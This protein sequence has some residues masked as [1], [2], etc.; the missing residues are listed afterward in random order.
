MTR[1][2][3]T[4]GL[5]ALLATAA[6][7]SLLAAGSHAAAPT[8]GTTVTSTGGAVT[9][10]VNIDLCCAQDPAEQT[11]YGPIIADDVKQAEDVW[12]QALA[13]LPYKGCFPIHVAFNARLLNDGE[14]PRPDAH[15]IHIDF[16]KPGRPYTTDPG[17]EGDH[18]RDDTTAYTD[19]LG[20]EFFYESMD[21]RAWRHEI[22][23]LMGLGDDYNDVD[24][25]GRTASVPLPGR[26][27][28]LMDGGPKI[29]DVLAR[30]LGDI[31]TKAGL[32]LPHCW[33]G[34]AHID[35]TFSPGCTM[36]ADLQLALTVGENGRVSGTSRGNA[37]YDRGGCGGGQQA[38]LANRSVTGEFARDRFVIQVRIA[39]GLERP[40]TVPLVSPTAARANNVHDD[41][42]IGAIGRRTY[43][44]KLDCA[45]CSG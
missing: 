24:A 22:G 7:G 5:L 17:M 3:R 12:N 32:K 37:L 26:Y 8:G 42:G 31:A 40:V 36:T 29:D 21:E 35:V 9:I 18:T 25:L 34:D 14:K 38:L 30:R 15:N 45:A 20:G 1:R 23:H 6:T 19:S 4:W 43:T 41:I 28:T 44:I 16:S 13:K 10:T 33:K 2:R 27:F 39:P 11:I